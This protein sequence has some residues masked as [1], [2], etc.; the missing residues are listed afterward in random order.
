MNKLGYKFRRQYSIG[1]F[2]VDFYCHEKKLA[3]EV[4]GTSHDNIIKSGYDQ[5]RDIFLNEHGI[6][7]IHIRAEKLIDSL[8]AIINY[9][10]E[11]LDQL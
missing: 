7:V 5:R 3:I 10:K 6:R 2:I 4:D 9:I 11:N 1:V 8:D